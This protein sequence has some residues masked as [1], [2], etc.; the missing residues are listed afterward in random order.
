MSI[1]LR[2]GL[3]NQ[4]LD[5][6][7]ED[8]LVRF[9]VNVPKEDLSSLE[10]VCFQ[11]EEGQWFYT[12]FVRLLNPSLPH[13]KMKS[14]APKILRMCPLMWKWGD[15]SEALS[16]FGKYK[17]TIPVRGIALLNKDLTKVLLVRG[18]E[19]GTWSFPRGK[20][21]KDE[22]DIECAI[23]EVREETSFDARKYVNE[24]DVLE[25]T[26]GGKNFRIYLA[27]DVPEDFNFEPLV[28]C[29]IADIK[30]FNIK[31]LRKSVRTNHNKF[32]VVNAMM[33]PLYVWVNKQKGSIN[34]TILMR[35]AEVKLK[36][37]MGLTETEPEV[38]NDA[39][40]E[41]LNI[42]QGSKPQEVPI[43]SNLPSWNEQV[44]A[45]SL[46]QQL[47]DIYAG[48]P[49]FFPFQMPPMTN[50]PLQKFPIPSFNGVFP[51]PPQPHLP[52]QHQSIPLSQFQQSPF[53]DSNPTK[54]SQAQDATSAAKA[55]NATHSKELLSILKGKAPVKVSANDAEAD[56]VLQTSDDSVSKKIEAPSKKITIL[57]RDKTFNDSEAAS[58]LSILGKKPPSPD[59]PKSL[60]TDPDSHPIAHTAPS[61]LN[62]LKQSRR[63]SGIEQ[64]TLPVKDYS[65]SSYDALQKKPQ[66]LEPSK[67]SSNEF[68]DMMKKPSTSEA[69]QN[70]SLSKSAQ[71]LSILKKNPV[72]QP[73]TS[74]AVN[75]EALSN[76][77]QF[78][79][80]L[81][82]SASQPPTSE[83]INS[84]QLSNP[85]QFLRILKKN[86]VTPSS[87]NATA[88]NPSDAIQSKSYRELS[89]GIPLSS[90]ETSEISSGNQI[91]AM[92][93][94]KVDTPQKSQQIPSSTTLVNAD[95][96]K[97]GNFDDFENFEDFDEI[98]ESQKDIYNSIANNFDLASDE[99]EF[100]DAAEFELPKA[101]PASAMTGSLKSLSTN[102]N[103]AGA[104]LLL[105]L[106]GNKPPQHVP[107][108]T[109]QDTYGA[110]SQT[111]QP[112][113]SA[114]SMEHNRSNANGAQ[115]LRLLKR[116][117][118]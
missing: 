26:I 47:S 92:L 97:F 108:S 10:R 73:P 83:P 54:Q 95:Y 109:L 85:A 96:S 60:D 48:V 33:E 9:V 53:P 63:D 90:H 89:G 117:K 40:R 32:Y 20:I 38:N 50:I 22:T 86:S 115:I 99:D 15:P 11:V 66:P 118:D 6:V 78:L 1:N 18:P 42:L 49:Q 14:F 35:E 113:P 70:K 61:F 39:G 43:S 80:I 106:N 12:D 25:R 100:I 62:I 27:K 75:N 110:N 77:A 8:I 88:S 81:K 29:E 112:Q 91:L 59:S 44:N 64:S 58:F 3:L 7:L 72:S 37:L 102:T 56:G 82:S 31:Q 69:I 114:N 2:D 17:S 116:D 36:K 79:N 94:R 74:E 101:K 24:N 103:S 107:Y 5:H 67:L 57:K 52:H 28:R 65:P 16:Q 93:N 68:L 41:L 13:M 87:T 76:S 71:F 21:S 51:Q 30:W 19:S 105:L 55:S 104:G 111:Q 45:P 84:E 34:E 98:S 4:P 23:R 46:P